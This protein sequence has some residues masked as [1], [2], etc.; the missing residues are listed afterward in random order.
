MEI[1]RRGVKSE[2]QLPAYTTATAMQDLSW[3]KAHS[4]SVA[5]LMATARSLTHWARPGIKAASSWVPNP[6]SHSRNS[7]L[8]DFNLLNHRSS[9]HGSV[10]NIRLGTM[11]FRVRSLASLSGLRIQCCYELR[12]RSQMPLGSHVAVAV[13]LAGGYSSDLTPSLGTSICWGSGPK[14]QKD[15]K[16]TKKTKKNYHREFPCGAVG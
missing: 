15:K 11:R 5:Q 6:L 13:A 4:T 8:C 12:C 3:V 14:R 1:P 2:L 7:P 9:R 16:K 10:V